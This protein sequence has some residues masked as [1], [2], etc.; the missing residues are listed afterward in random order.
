[1]ESAKKKRKRFITDTSMPKVAIISDI[2]GNLAAL[3]PFGALGDHQD[4]DILLI[5]GDISPARGSHSFYDQQAWFYGNFLPALAEL[6]VGH[7]CFIAGNH[8]YFLSEVTAS[9]NE[10]V[11]RNRLPDNIHYLRDSGVEILGLNIWGTPWVSLP[12][13]AKF[14]KGF[15]VWNFAE[16]EDDLHEHFERIPS[17]LDILLSHGPAHG[18]CDVIDPKQATYIGEVE[19]VHCGSKALQVHVL[20]KCPKF[21]FCGHIHSGNHGFEI[22]NFKVGDSYRQV[23]FSNVSSLNEKYELA[24]KPQ[25]IN[26]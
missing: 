23:H 2:H 24:Y 6:K 13:W 4:A 5:G 8:D 18:F 3:A 10:D 20:T 17:G 11:I 15:S 14:K 16:Q 26:I 1:M 12:P 21:V 7:I 22:F 9:K 25:M 19:D